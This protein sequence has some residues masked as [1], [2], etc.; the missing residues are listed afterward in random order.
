MWRGALFPVADAV[1]FVDEAGQQGRQVW[2]SESTVSTAG[3]LG[4]ELQVPQALSSQS[5]LPT[6]L[7]LCDAPSPE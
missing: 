4:A 6:V 5:T 1:W 7:L 3:R 2:K